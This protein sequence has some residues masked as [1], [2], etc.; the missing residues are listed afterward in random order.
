MR[1]QSNS[2]TRS[3]SVIEAGAERLYVNLLAKIHGLSED[4][5]CLPG[6]SRVAI[7]WC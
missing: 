1:R 2:M 3:G 4:L 5:D 7:G 6:R